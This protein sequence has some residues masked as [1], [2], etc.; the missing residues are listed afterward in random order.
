MKKTFLFAV[1]TA[2]FMTNI[3]A[4]SG[5]RVSIKLIT[6]ANGLLPKSSV[7]FKLNYMNGTSSEEYQIYRYGGFTNGF[8]PKTTFD[9]NVE[10][11]HSINLSDIKGF[12]IRH[13]S[14]IG[15]SAEPYDNWDLKGLEINLVD[16][17]G[18]RTW[19]SRVYKSDANFMTHFNQFTKTFT[20][21]I[22]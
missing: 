20:L 7:Y 9:A 8:A 14:A 3:F 13:V 16:R 18:M 19:T 12:T 4:Q 11:T 17:L 6:G 10:L 21:S 1:L 2:F 5:T 22:Q 15:N